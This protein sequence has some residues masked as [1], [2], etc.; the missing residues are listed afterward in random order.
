M[1]L[2]STVNGPALAAVAVIAAAVIAG[3]FSYLNL[4]TTKRLG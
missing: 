1:A 4:I 2:E 3:S